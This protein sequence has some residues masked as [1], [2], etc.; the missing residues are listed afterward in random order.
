MRKY[1]LLLLCAAV[2][3]FSGCLFFGAKSP[4]QAL[5]EQKITTPAAIE[6]DVAVVAG[7]GLLEDKRPAQDISYLSSVREN[8]SAQVL[9]AIK[10]TKIFSK[11]NYPALSDEAFIIRGEIRRF[12]WE[13][14]ETMISYIP[15]MNVFNLF[16][17]PATRTH[18][19]VDIYIQVIEAKSNKVIFDIAEQNVKKATYNIYNFK[20]SKAT[21][22]LS[23]CFRLV[24]NKIRQRFA[25]EKKKI[26]DAL[27]PGVPVVQKKEL[28]PEEAKVVEEKVKAA[29]EKMKAAEEKIREV[30]KK[31]VVVEEMAK[32]VEEK[33]KA[34][35]ERIKAAEKK[36]ESPSTEAS[37]KKETKSQ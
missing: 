19:E 26:I 18:A 3:V 11:I 13:S 20:E 9:D 37:E 8:V 36:V 30:E 6:S 21:E 7:F 23:S 24:L 1:R 5:A 28:A 17:L 4:R 14:F 16:G 32:K 29:E 33:M 35:E 15:V 34:A 22:E 10:A 25:V 12:H 27:K 31:A 2:S